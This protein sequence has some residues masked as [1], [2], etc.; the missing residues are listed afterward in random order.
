MLTGD[1]SSA[2]LVHHA[3]YAQINRTLWKPPVR[4]SDMIATIGLWPC[5]RLAKVAQQSSLLPA[6]GA[7][8]V[9]LVEV[10]R[11]FLL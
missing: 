3:I 10:D 6:L 1:S 8:Q 7:T 4:W 2:L 5:L 9:L 11:R